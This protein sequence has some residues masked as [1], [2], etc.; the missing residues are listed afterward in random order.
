M[1]PEI[2]SALH[3]EM[4]HVEEL[5]LIEVATAGG[6]GNGRGAFGL[7]AILG[8]LEKGEV[9]IMLWQPRCNTPGEPASTCTNRG[10]FRP[11][12]IKSCDLC[13]QPA[14]QFLRSEEAL[15]RR[16]I[17]HRLDDDAIEMRMI[18]RTEVPLTE[19]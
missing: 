14:R 8:A 16:V 13:G 1:W 5:K 2:E 12:L 4:D 18:G 19:E 3:S 15:I 10:H 17:G 6:E 11:R 9:Q 7:P